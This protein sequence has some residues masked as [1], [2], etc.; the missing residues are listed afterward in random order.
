MTHRIFT[1]KF[2]KIFTLLIALHTSIL[3]AQKGSKIGFVDIKSVLAQYLD[4]QPYVQEVYNKRDLFIREAKRRQRR[5]EKIKEDVTRLSPAGESTDIRRLQSLREEILFL[6]SE[7]GNFISEKDY[8]LKMLE[9]S[10]SYFAL[11]IIYDHIKKI[12]EKDGYYIILEYSGYVLHL[13]DAI[14][15]TDEV[16][17]VIVRD[18]RRRKTR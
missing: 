8:E 13:D 5:I 2:Q 16:L 6:E 7:L 3:F 18:K 12:A 11:K 17:K 14:N 10:H 9:Q 4:G 1:T 15:I